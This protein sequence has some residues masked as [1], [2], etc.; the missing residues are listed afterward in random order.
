MLAPLLKC[1][2]GINFNYLQ[3]GSG[4]KGLCQVDCVKLCEDDYWIASLP[5][6]KDFDWIREQFVDKEYF[7]VAGGMSFRKQLKHF[8]GNCLNERLIR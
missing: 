1:T 5:S 4:T 6:I 3:A 2:D 8:V 7:Q